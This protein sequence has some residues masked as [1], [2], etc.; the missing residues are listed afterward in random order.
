MF[1]H[2]EIVHQDDA[3]ELD[4]G[5]SRD[6]QQLQYQRPLAT[7]RSVEDDLLRFIS[8]EF[9]IVHNPQYAGAQHSYYPSWKPE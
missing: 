6:S 1:F 4:A 8:I 9:E 7:V 3:K 2:G 5:D